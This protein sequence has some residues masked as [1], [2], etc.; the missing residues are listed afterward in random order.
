MQLDNLSNLLGRPAATRIVFVGWL[1]LALAA[2]TY[3]PRLDVLMTKGSDFTQDYLAIQALLRGESIYDLFTPDQIAAL[4]L[5]PYAL[6]N[7]HPPATIVLLLP[8]GLLP[9]QQAVLLWS[10][11]SLA[12]Y[13]WLW[14]VTL[15]ALGL[16][17]LPGW[18][19]LLVGVSLLWYPFQFHMILAQLS[20]PL[21]ACVI[22]SWLALRAGRERLAGAL[23]GL[24][25]LIKLFP[26]LLLLYF[27][28]RRRWQALAAAVA[29]VGAGLLLTLAVVGVDD[30][31]RYRQAIAP[32]NLATFSGEMHNLSFNGAFTRLLAGSPF[33]APLVAAPTM[34]LALTAAACGAVLIALGAAAWRLPRDRRGDDLAIALVCVAMPLLNPISWSHS[35]VLLIMPAALAV[36]GLVDAPDPRWARVAAL[37]FL[38][39]SVPDNALA[40]AIA[41]H[42]QPA[43]VPWFATLPMLLTTA[44]ALL[45]LALLLAR[46]RPRRAAPV[47]R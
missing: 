28:V 35:F 10:G 30:M 5:E 32:A 33:I 15:R 39:I 36:R 12:L 38:L 2:L 26:A 44:G 11:L 40:R 46:G 9:Y 14:H 25:I 16:S 41:R 23:L 1:V 19:P 31:L 27:V 21:T 13:L 43:L 4:G 47:P 24:A 42:Y 29:V 37:A 6:Q 20:I 8:L 22:G 3:L 18:A 17:L 45:L 7:Y 34:A